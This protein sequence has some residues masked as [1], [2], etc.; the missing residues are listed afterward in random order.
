MLDIAKRKDGKS[1]GRTLRDYKRESPTMNRRR[2]LPP[3]L[4]PEWEEHEIALLRRLVSWGSSSPRAAIALKRSVVS[5]RSKAGELGLEFP[6]W[7][8]P[9]QPDGNDQIQDLPPE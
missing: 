6:N 7:H 9:A 8:K 5:V 4:E 2:E 1:G 3:E